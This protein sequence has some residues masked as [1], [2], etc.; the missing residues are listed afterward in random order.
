[1]R[2]QIGRNSKMN[3]LKCAGPEEM[4]NPLDAVI[5]EFQD[6]RGRIACPYSLQVADLLSPYALHFV[7][8][9]ELDANGGVCGSCAGKIKKRGLALM[10][11]KKEKPATIKSHHYFSPQEDHCELVN[12][13]AEEIVDFNFD[14]I[15]ETLGFIKN[16]PES[17][18]NET[19]QL[20]SKLFGWCFS[21]TGR[22]RLKTAA[23]RF[24]AIVAGIRPDLLDNCSQGE[25]AKQ[26]GLTK[27]A[28]SKTSLKFQSQ[29]DIK[30]HRS[31]SIAARSNM[32]DAR[33][34]KSGNNCKRSIAVL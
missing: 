4:G 1:M 10:N 8:Q 2:S 26:L 21:S 32:A 11:G 30:F 19:G 31:R 14:G 24:A 29:F 15:D 22:N 18:R 34:G 17:V 20:A 6:T 28:F 9:K 7:S 3:N 33:R 5:G 25:L 13:H 12:G 23:L 27:A 16:S